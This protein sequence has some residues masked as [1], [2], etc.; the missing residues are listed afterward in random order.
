MFSK[1]KKEKLRCISFGS[2]SIKLI[3]EQET[4]SFD[5]LKAKAFKSI[6]A[7]GFRNIREV[8]LENA[9]CILRVSIK[10]YQQDGSD[11]IYRV[12]QVECYTKKY[13]GEWI[14]GVDE[15]K[16]KPDYDKYVYGMEISQN[17]TV[18][19]KFE[20]CDYYLKVI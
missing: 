2:F 14:T 11:S 6:M 9:N 13:T 17:R 10:I 16:L 8:P 20:Y 1:T 5:S 12:N 18:S 19:F 4:V 3:K 15:K 7:L